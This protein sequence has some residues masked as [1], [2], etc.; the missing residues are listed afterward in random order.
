MRTLIQKD[1]FVLWLS[2]RDTHDW[3]H[4]PHSAWPCS[5]IS[6]KRLTVVFDANGLC[7]L[8]IN[9]RDADNIDGAELSAMVSDFMRAKL[10]TGHS[11]RDVAVN[12][13]TE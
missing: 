11:C 9:G 6:D 8:S 5:T 1:G 7:D 13:F 2:A 12:Q 10:P 4:Q 3:A